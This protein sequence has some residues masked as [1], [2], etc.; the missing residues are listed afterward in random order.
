MA[1]RHLITRKQ[2]L[3]LKTN[4]LEFDKDVLANTARIVHT[5]LEVFEQHFG[6]STNPMADDIHDIRVHYAHPHSDKNLNRFIIS[7]VQLGMLQGMCS[8]FLK[9]PYDVKVGMLA[10]L[11]EVL[12]HQAIGYSVEPIRIDNSIIHKLFKS[13]CC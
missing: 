5:I 12:T 2:I 1:N 10:T 9:D 11:D 13:H 6:Y 8:N 4:V 7:G 3:E